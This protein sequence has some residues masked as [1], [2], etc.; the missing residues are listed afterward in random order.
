MSELTLGRAVQRMARLAVDPATD[1]G[2]KISVSAILNEPIPARDGMIWDTNGMQIDNFKRNN[3]LGWNHDPDY[4]AIGRVSVFKSKNR[5][6]GTV[7]FTP[8]DV[9]PH[10]AMIGRMYRDGYLNA[11]SIGIIPLKT[12]YQNDGAGNRVC[13]VTESDLLDV[14]CVMWPAAPSALVTDRSQLALARSAAW[15]P[16]GAADSAAQSPLQR[17]CAARRAAVTPSI[18][19]LIRGFN[20][21]G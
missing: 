15:S 9:N 11:F 7:T 1:D 16:N 4:P 5:L 17:L 10:G 8:P 20:A 19:E 13:V 21:K 2:G 12:K 6:L 18:H 3:G 14:S